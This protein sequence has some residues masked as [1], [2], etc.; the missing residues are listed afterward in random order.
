MMNPPTR[1]DFFGNRH[2]VQ[3][4]PRMSKDMYG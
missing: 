2:K 4:I 1:V 3:I